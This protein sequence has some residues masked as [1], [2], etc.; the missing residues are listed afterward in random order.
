VA[1]YPREDDGRSSPCLCRSRADSQR[2]VV[3]GLVLLRTPPD[4]DLHIYRSRLLGNAGFALS[5]NDLSRRRCAS[6]SS[7]RR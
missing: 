7:R 5:S 2:W 1:A 4:V 6:T 3:A